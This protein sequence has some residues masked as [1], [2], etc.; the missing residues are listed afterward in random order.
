MKLMKHSIF[1]STLCLLVLM[2]CNDDDDSRP[3]VD[4]FTAAIDGEV[5]Q[6]QS[7]KVLIKRENGV[8]FSREISAKIV[9]DDF[10][11]KVLYFN[12]AGELSTASTD[13]NFTVIMGVYYENDYADSWINTAGPG[14]IEFTLAGYNAQR[15]SGSFSDFV[16][17]NGSDTLFISEISFSNIPIRYADF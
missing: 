11:E 16:A 4:S 5:V 10:V 9:N 2:G 13:S 15:V 3:L 7:P 12:Y 8:P 17:V 14:S 6:F 1:I